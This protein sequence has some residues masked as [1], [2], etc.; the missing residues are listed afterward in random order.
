MTSFVAWI[1]VDQRGPA[2][3]YFASD[4]RISWEKTQLWDK[5]RWDSGRKVF[6][7]RTQPDLLGYVGD[8]L[9]PSL[10]LGQIVEAIDAGLLYHPDASPMIKF[11]SIRMAI[12]QS[13]SG[14]PTDQR[15][16]MSIVFATREHTNMESV[17]HLWVLT[18]N[19]GWHV[20]SVQIPKVSSAIKILGSGAPV[21]GLWG[22]RWDSSSQG[23]TSRAVFAA[24]CDAIMSGHDPLSGGA[25]QLVGVFRISA[26]RSFGVSWHGQSFYHGLAV[27]IKVAAI[28]EIEWR[29]G[30]FER[31]DAMG[32]TLPDA[33]HHHKPRGLGL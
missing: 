21:I 29:N 18:W 8:V 20:E 4:S 15:R 27:D 30:L 16:P 17:F 23:R 2:S 13:F 19:N 12:E 28:Q 26:A 14:L 31:T 6:A 1:G 24:L 5:G 11:D 9:F 3:I 10:V 25:P 33:Q 22:G 32:A 7:T